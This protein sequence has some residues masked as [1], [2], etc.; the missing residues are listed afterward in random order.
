MVQ[1][2]KHGRIELRIERTIPPG[3]FLKVSYTYR[4]KS[5]K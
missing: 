3:G 5:A 4:L 2:E 1:S